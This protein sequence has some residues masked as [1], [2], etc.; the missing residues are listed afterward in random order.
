MKKTISLTIIILMVVQTMAAPL[1]NRVKPRIVVNIVVGQMRYDYLLRFADNLSEKGFR[2]LITN[3]S[4]CDRAQLNY[5]TT[6]TPSGLATISTGANP[7]THGVIG[8]GRTNYTTGERTELLKDDTVLTV[9]SD[10]LDAQLSP[11]G[12][13][14]STIGDVIKTVSPESRVI[15]VA[16]EAAS[17]VII[18]GFLP[19]AAYWVSPRDGR[20]VSNSYYMQQ[21]PKWVQDFNA[22]QVAEKYS[23]ESWRVLRAAG[24]YHNIISRDIVRDSSSNFLNF[25]FLTRKKYDYDRLATSPAANTLLRDFAIQAIIYENLGKDDATD[26]INIV[27]DP[28]RKV[29]EKYGSQSMEVEDCFYRMDAEIASFREFLETQFGKE[30]VLLVVSS[31]HGAADPVTDHSRLPNGR[32]DTNQFAILMNGFLGAQLGGDQRWVLDFSDNQIYLDRRLIYEKG[33]N[34][35]DIQDK[36]A[37]FAIQFRGVAQAIT[38][39]SMSSGYF[40]GGVMGRAQ[41][42]YFPRHSGDVVLNL[43]PG[44]TVDNNKL[45]DSG[46]PYN[47][48][49]HIPLIWWGGMVGTQDV[50]REVSAEDIAPTIAHIIGI[51]PPNAATGRPIVDIYR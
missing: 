19:D 11:K 50:S 7:S 26:L 21:L 22:T 9:G 29:G 36:V 12:L 39:H 47:Y 25:D 6:S 3:G 37:A 15:S 27:F 8:N 38:S 13:Y 46:S 14:A 16:F 2:Y 43:L 5:L 18:G 23:S 4:S 42:S 28:S 51:A 44:W 17:A 30:K 1:E 10:E 33:Y 31:D 48:D 49:T 24:S 41:N 34:L 45:S 20:F 35:N 40:A 32:F